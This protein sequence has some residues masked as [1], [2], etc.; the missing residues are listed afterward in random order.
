MS[1]GRGV[2]NESFKQIISVLPRGS[3]DQAKGSRFKGPSLVSSTLQQTS[4]LNF[5]KQNKYKQARVQFK[6]L[7]S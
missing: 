7:I 2:F 6:M 1:S 3:L 5:T 4:T